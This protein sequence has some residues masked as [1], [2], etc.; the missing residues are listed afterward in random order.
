VFVPATK[1]ETFAC[2]V[3][4]ALADANEVRRIRLG[5]QQRMAGLGR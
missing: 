1:P 5:M 4:R 3:T 2:S